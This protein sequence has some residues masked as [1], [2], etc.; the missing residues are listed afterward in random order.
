MECGCWALWS[1]TGEICPKKSWVKTDDNGQLVLLDITVGRGHLEASCVMVI[2]GIEV[3]G[4]L[5]W[6]VG[7][8]R[9]GILNRMWT[10]GWLKVSEQSEYSDGH[11]VDV[12][13]NPKSHCESQRSF[14]SMSPGVSMWVFQ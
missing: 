7:S 11:G 6:N 3:P 4:M 2:K 1:V 13:V 8:G 12:W 9:Q 10:V 14:V 5:Q